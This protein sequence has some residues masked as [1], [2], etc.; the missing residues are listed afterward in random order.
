VA[1]VTSVITLSS[2]RGDIIV[3]DVGCRQPIGMGLYLSRSDIW[4]F[5]HNDMEDLERILKEVVASHKGGTLPRR[6]IVVEGLY[7]NYGDVC[8]LDKVVTLAKK[9]KFR[10]LLDDSLALGVLGQQGRGSFEHFGLK[11]TDVELYVADLGFA[12]GTIGGI[13]YGAEDFVA[14]QR[15]NGSG[16]VFSASNPPY[17]AHTAVAFLEQLRKDPSYLTRLREN[18]SRFYHLLKEKLDGV[19]LIHGWE[20][21]PVLHLSLIDEPEDRLEADSILEEI[22]AEAMENDVALVRCK[23]DYSKKHLPRPSIRTAIN[24]QHLEEDLIKTADVIRQAAIKILKS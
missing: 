2:K 9:Y 22:C 19:L 13:S 24:S 1:A 16:Y 23:Y 5:K 18:S 21:S 17:L 8:P 3:S 4:Y 14:H 10:V 12:F 20:Y 15:L 6:L 11:T 7:Y